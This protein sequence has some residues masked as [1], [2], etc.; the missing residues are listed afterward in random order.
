MK[1]VV[2]QFVTFLVLLLLVT[3]FRFPYHDFGMGLFE[4]LRTDLR[5]HGI[6]LDVDSVDLQFPGQLSV[7]NLSLLIPTGKLPF[8]FYA[9][10]ANLDPKLLPL[11]LLRA[12]LH[13]S[14]HAYKGTLEST[15]SHPLLGDHT[16]V[17]IEGK[18]LR[19]EE[20]PLLKPLGVSGVA[21]LDADLS[22]KPAP[23]KMPRNETPVR[24]AK[25]ALQIDEGAYR[26][27]HKIRGIFTLPPIEDIRGEL[28]ADFEKS[29]LS[30]N[31]LKVF[32][33][34]GE[35]EGNGRLGLNSAMLIET[36]NLSATLELTSEGARSLNG[37]LA[38]AAGVGH[39]QGGGLEGQ[40]GQQEE[41]E[42]EGRAVD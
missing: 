23:Q 34:L 20:H 17:V 25:L 35:L 30:L 40:R 29:I 22:L 14:V 4:D 15:L 37:Y 19:L 9:D 26:G 33:S 6:L 32:S 11:F 28:K 7:K 16:S 27:G 2:S 39:G 12:V 21:N 10:E 42:H 36:L 5:R 24:S 1:R 31:S 13:S 3:A 18:T 8:P 41:S 38:L